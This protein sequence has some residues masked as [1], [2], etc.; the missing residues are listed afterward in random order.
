MAE[1]RESFAAAVRAARKRKGLTQLKLAE[2]TGMSLDAIGSL[3]RGIT[4]PTV[5]TAGKLIRALEIDANKIFAA[6][7]G[8]RAADARRLDVESELQQLMAGLTDQGANLLLQLAKAVA[9]VHAAPI[10]EGDRETSD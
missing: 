7:P 5:D 10:A 9:G 3:E 2:V 1:I 8:R 4:A 6:V